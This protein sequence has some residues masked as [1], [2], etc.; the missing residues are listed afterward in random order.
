MERASW[1]LMIKPPRPDYHPVECSAM[2]SRHPLTGSLDHCDENGMIKEAP[3]MMPVRIIISRHFHEAS[4]DW[5][6]HDTFNENV[7]QGCIKPMTQQDV[8]T[9]HENPPVDCA[10]FFAHRWTNWGR[11][12]SRR[13]NWSRRRHRRLSWWVP[14][15]SCG[16]FL[17][18]FNFT[19]SVDSREEPCLFWH[20]WAPGSPWHQGSKDQRASEEGRTSSI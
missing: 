16:S 4:T 20:E 14:L 3:A 5:C 19:F 13:I 9:F 15:H 6:L 2:W 10:S 1:I 7:L 11:S 17:H 18:W 8:V 12:W